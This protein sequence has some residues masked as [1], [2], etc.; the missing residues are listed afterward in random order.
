MNFDAAPIRRFPGNALAVTRKCGSYSGPAAAA[1]GVGLVEHRDASSA[2]TD[3]VVDQA[4]GLLAIGC[5]QVEREVSV[6]RLALGLRAGEREEKV[7]VPVL[8]LLEHG[9]DAGHRRRAHIAEQQEH[10]VLQHEG[11]GVPDGRVRLVA[12][13]IGLDGYAAAANAAPVVDVLE[14]GAGA[15]VQL[16]SQAAR[17]SGE[18]GRHAK[19]DFG[20]GNAGTGGF[21]SDGPDDASP[22]AIQND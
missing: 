4:G 16:D 14:V 20:V 7:D 11:H 6:R 13:V 15:P 12:V 5:A 17:R 1:V 18:R 2:D 3:E 22:E 8:E 19:G 21:R 10:L 9:Q